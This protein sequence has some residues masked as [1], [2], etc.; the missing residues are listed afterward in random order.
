MCCVG[1]VFLSAGCW[2]S[3]F[4]S[5]LRGRR[6]NPLL[7]IITFIVQWEF[8]DMHS[9]HLLDGLAK[10]KLIVSSIVRSLVTNRSK[11]VHYKHINMLCK[12]IFLDFFPIVPLSPHCVLKLVKILFNLFWESWV[13]TIMATILALLDSW[14]TN[15]SNS[16]VLH[17]LYSCITAWQ[18]L[19][20]IGK[21]GHHFCD[22]GLSSSFLTQNSW[23][24]NIQS[25][26]RR[27]QS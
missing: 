21:L 26:Y 10:A 16:L 9:F 13:I 14:M 11:N 18:S 19:K 24:Q 12:E 3:P 15:V 2:W 4:N 27:G 25:F 17:S 1:A 20:T 5:T 6:W 23:I 8:K 22:G 7:E